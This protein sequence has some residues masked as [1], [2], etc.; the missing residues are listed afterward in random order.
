[1]KTTIHSDRKVMD[2]QLDFN[3]QFPFLNLEFF[4]LSPDALST[5]VSSGDRYPDVLVSDL[6]ESGANGDLFIYPNMT[7][8]QLEHQLYDEFGLKAQVFVKTGNSW[9]RTSLNGFW[10][11]H[12]KNEEGRRSAYSQQESV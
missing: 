1:M 8:M 10:R 4:D 12:H 5:Y 6:R 7:I 9:M 3:R 11:L 2:I